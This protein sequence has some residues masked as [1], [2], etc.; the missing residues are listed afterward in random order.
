MDIKANDMAQPIFTLSPE[1]QQ[2]WDDIMGQ[3][4][5]FVNDTNA[6]VDSAYD[7]VCEMLDISS[8]VDNNVAWDSFYETWESC[9]NRNDLQYNFAW[10]FTL[11]HSPLTNIIMQETKF[12]LYGEFIRPNGHQNYDILSYIAE[13]R[14][15]AIATCKRL[16]PHFNIITIQV[17]DTAPEVVKV[18][19]LVWN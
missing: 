4:C 13:T 2:S 8:F 16:N 18:Q 15:E 12:N 5:A 10:F 6:D 11:T 14:E 7:W 17:D 3:M 19:S 1:M 9:D